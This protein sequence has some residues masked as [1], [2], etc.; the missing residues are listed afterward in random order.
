M[1]SVFQFTEREERLN[2]LSFFMQSDV[3][4]CNAALLRIGVA[5]RIE[6]LTEP[7]AEAR[8]CAGLYPV[9]L[10]QALSEY[11]WGFACRVAELAPVAEKAPPGWSW[12][13]ALP[14]D[15]LRLLEIFDSAGPKRS[16]PGYVYEQIR[17][18]SG[19]QIVCNLSP[20]LVRYVGRMRDAAGFSAPFASALA[21]RIAADL[22]VALSGDP[23]RMKMCLDVADMEFRRAAAHD[24]TQQSSPS[25]P[26]AEWIAAH[27]R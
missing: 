18:E 13:Y 27:D 2:G 12:R 1:K 7:S 25:L 24:A 16:A 20:C 22:A 23:S 10:D 5:R 26:D 3:S 19:R 21:W 6:S 11:P 15:C 4:I 14:T 17:G 9:V 8:Y